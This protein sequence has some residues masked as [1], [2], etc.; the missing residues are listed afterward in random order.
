MTLEQTRQERCTSYAAFL[1]E[2][3]DAGVL[4]E[5][6][7]LSQWVVWRAELDREGKKKKIP[8]NPRYTNAKASVKIPKS[9]GTLDASL[10]ALASGL[11]SGIG[12]M[13]TPT[14]VF[15]DLDHCVSN[16]TGEITDPQAAEIVAAIHSYTETSPSGTG[17]HILAYGTLPGKNFHTAIEIY[18][19]ERFTTIT[20]DHLRETPDTIE[21]RQEAIA[22]LYRRF[23]SPLPNPQSQN[24]RGG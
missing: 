7:G 3:F 11:Y 2:R 19:Q 16:N 5:L 14:L 6:Q 21:H 9:G 24:T 15:L 17:L 23:A 4:S 10:T 1:R 20:T 12:L 8:Y 13:L 18:G 22:A